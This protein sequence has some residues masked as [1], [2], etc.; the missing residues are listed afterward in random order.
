M[1]RK[2]ST[3][4]TLV[5][6]APWHCCLAECWV[7]LGPPGPGLG[8]EAE[9]FQRSRTD[10]QTATSG[11]TG[12]DEGQGPLH[13][14]PPWQGSKHTETETLR[15]YPPKAPLQSCTL[16]NGFT[17]IFFCADMASR[18]ALS[19]RKCSTGR[20]GST[21]TRSLLGAHVD[22][23][24]NPTEHAQQSRAA[25]GH[26]TPCPSHGLSFRSQHQPHAFEPPLPEPMH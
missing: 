22:A 9:D 5:A 10:W 25:P 8:T 4:S 3:C 2:S 16:L 20:E 23:K 15:L 11:A 18:G 21:Q 19:C 24:L 12:R 7:L 26:D 1:L 14:Q 17:G 6:A 13:L